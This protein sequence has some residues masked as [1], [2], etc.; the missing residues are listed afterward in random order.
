MDLSPELKQEALEL[1]SLCEH[2]TE[3]LA[4]VIFP[5]RFTFPFSI[6]H[7][8]IFN[9][10]D[11]DSLQKVC[12]IAP[13]GTGKTSILQLA[14]AAR[15]IL[16][17]QSKYIVPIG[18]NAV[19]AINQSEILKREL[20]TNPMIGKLW[21]NLKSSYFTKEQWVTSSGTMVM[22]RGAGQ[23]VRGLLFNNDRPDLFLLDDLEDDESVMSELQR[24]KMQQYLYDAVLNAVDYK[25]DNWR[26]I[27]IGTLLHEA[28]LL[29]IIEDEYHKCI[30]AGR[31]PPWH[32]INLSICDEKYK[33]YWPE[34]YSDTWIQEKLQEYAAMGMLD[35]FAREFMGLPVSSDSNFKKSYFQRYNEA[36]LSEDIRKR[37]INI[38]LLDPAK[39]VTSTSC[40]SAIVV[41]GVDP[42]GQSY[43]LRDIVSGRHHPDEVVDF[44]LDAAMRWG[45]KVLGVEVTSLN[46]WI[47]YPI[48]NEMV[49]TNRNIQLLELKARGKKE[50]RSGA[51]LPYYRR[52]QVFHNQAIADLIEIPLLSWPRCKKWDTID[53]MSYLPEALKLGDRYLLA[54]GSDKNY[55]DESVY[56]LLKKEDAKMPRLR[57]RSLA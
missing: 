3:L 30:K 47:T 35:S 25:E 10:I 53:A 29:A 19:N 44:A 48:I 52:K 16:F 38:V 36:E 37:L 39:T 50:D 17:K 4:K 28:S 57:R 18:N 32:V 2:N 15:R 24:M 55:T 40:E 31:K 41:W 51:M 6:I 20:L 33:S 42:I 11:D 12:I 26:V 9:V 5:E 1:I 43:Y 27:L 34:A 45:A 56:E 23:A 13:R 8:E 21:G 49:R 46:E 54:A 7:R 22:P 14:Y